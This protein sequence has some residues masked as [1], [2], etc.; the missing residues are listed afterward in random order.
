MSS[1]FSENAVTAFSEK[2]DDKSLKI[3][4]EN[5]VVYHIRKE[6]IFQLNLTLQHL[7]TADADTLKEFI[8]S[9]GVH[10]PFSLYIEDESRGNYTVDN[11]VFANM[12]EITYQA[13][14]NFAVSM[15]LRE[16]K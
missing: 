11:V 16:V 6:P 7:T 5:L 4:T 2:Y 8:Y 10:T 14:N 3:E 1:Y 9:H 13:Y 12:P 15:R